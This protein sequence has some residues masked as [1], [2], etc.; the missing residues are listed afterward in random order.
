VKAAPAP[1]TAATTEETVTPEMLALRPELLVRLRT[2]EREVWPRL[3]QTMAMGEIEGFATRLYELAERGG[4]A[5][6]RAYARQIAQEAAEFDLDRLPQ[7]LQ[8]FPAL[9]QE[10]AS[11]DTRSQ[12]AVSP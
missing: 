8:E 9:C 3:C 4:W 10:L 1:A 12:P 7:T 2:E 6:L 11:T 5:D